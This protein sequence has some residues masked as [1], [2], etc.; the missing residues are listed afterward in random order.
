ML[1]DLTRIFEGDFT[2]EA[3]KQGLV[4]IVLGLWSLLLQQQAHA[5][6]DED[7]VAAR[8]SHDLVD[9]ITAEKTRVFPRELFGQAVHKLEARMTSLGTAKGETLHM[10][11]SPHMDH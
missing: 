9:K 10:D 2:V 4:P 6:Q 1:S 3:D 5:S 7:T 8:L 11:D